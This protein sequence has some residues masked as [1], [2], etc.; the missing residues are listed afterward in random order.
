MS[1]TVKRELPL[2]FK[3]G[4]D[5]RAAVEF[6]VSIH[7]ELRLLHIRSGEVQRVQDLLGGLH[8]LLGGKKHLNSRGGSGSR[9]GGG[10]EGPGAKPQNPGAEG[11][12]LRRITN[13]KKETRKRGA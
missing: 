11:E 3:G 1:S 9:G 6:A 7:N 12:C 5:G 4:S 2:Q 10:G 8:K 13:F